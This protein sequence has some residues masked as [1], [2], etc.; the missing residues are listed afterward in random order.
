MKASRECTTGSVISKDGTTIG[1]RQT[2]HG[3]GLLLVHGA[4]QTSQSF[5][6]LAASLCDAFTVYVSDRRGRGLSGPFGDNYGMEREV[7]DIE[8]ILHKTGARNIFGL[9]SGALIALQAALALSSVRKVALYEPPLA[10]NNALSP[11]AW[12]PRYEQELARG[13]LAAAMVASIAGTSDPSLFTALPRFILVPLI[14]LALK[15]SAKKVGTEHA[16][17]GTLIPT[18]HFDTLLVA[19]MA[20]TIEKFRAVRSEVLLMGG[21]R[22][23]AY[24]PLALN[25]LNS[26]LPNARRVELSGLGHLAADNGGAPERVADELRR[27]FKDSRSIARDAPVA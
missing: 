1:Y 17:L 12:V 16:L 10:T 5:S 24:L 20:G 8:A 7:D 22:S 4:M 19:E 25:A 21:S 15:A 9:S 13:D 26:A 3:P 14:R 18:V 11:M 23:V 27:F 2:G 6:K